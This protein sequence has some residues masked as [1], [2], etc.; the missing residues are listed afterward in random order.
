MVLGSHEAVH[1]KR[2]DLPSPLACGKSCSG[3]EWASEWGLARREIRKGTAADK[4]QSSRGNDHHAAECPLSP[5]SS[6]WDKWRSCPQRLLKGCNVGVVVGICSWD[7]DHLETHGCPPARPKIAAKADEWTA[8]NSKYTCLPGIPLQANESNRCLQKR[9][10]L[11]SSASCNFCY[12]W[13][14]FN[15]ACWSL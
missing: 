10:P 5:G 15:L 8:D 3:N 6:H 12:E 14:L 9:T 7:G 2:Q 1:R 11:L 4:S 13:H